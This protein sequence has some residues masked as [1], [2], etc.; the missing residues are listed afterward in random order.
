MPSTA[1]S[2]KRPI[3]SQRIG[4]G[5]PDAVAAAELGYVG[6]HRE[7]LARNHE[8]RVRD[9]RLDDRPSVHL[10]RRGDERLVMQE[11]LDPLD[12]HVGAVRVL[13]TEVAGAGFIGN[14][15]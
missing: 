5:R 9:R 4:L 3:R 2:K 10:L 1:W 6:V 14:E 8:V 11:R 12:T 7:L 13:L 15:Q